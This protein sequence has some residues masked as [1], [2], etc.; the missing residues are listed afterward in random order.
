MNATTRIERRKST[1]YQ[2]FKKTLLAMPN[3]SYILL[4]LF[5]VVCFAIFFTSSLDY[6]GKVALIVFVIAMILW[7]ATKLP[8]G[9]VALGAILSIILLKGADASLLYDSFSLEIVW[10]M[11]GAFIIGEVIKVSGLANRI[12]TN[13]MKNS[14][15]SNSV[16]FHVLIALL[17]LSI[18]IP[19]TSGRAAITLPVVKELAPFIQ[20]DKHKQVLAMFV[21]TII[22]MTTSATLIGAGSHLIGVEILE[23]T[24]GETITYLNWLI[25]GVPFA[26]FISFVSY[27]AVRLLW[28]R[29]KS[30]PLLSLTKKHSIFTKNEK[31][32]EKEKKALIFIGTLFLLWVTE[33]IHGHDIGFITIMGALVFMSPKF[34]L[35]SWKQGVKSVSWNLILFVSAATALGINLVETGVVDWIESSIFQFVTSFSNFSVWGMLCFILLVSITSHLYITSHTTRAIVLVPGLL[36]LGTSFGFNGIAVLFLSLVGMNYCLTFPVSSKALLVY[37]EEEKISYKAKD[38]M[39]LSFLLMPIYFISILLFYYTYW[40]WTGLTL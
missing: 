17:P 39:R 35:L 27:L 36:M 8:A 2:I 18:F 12:I 34:G 7:I 32:T 38:L 14:A 16:L 40:D 19:S 22:L 6:K 3:Y 23:K 13:I 20:D 33:G 10:L 4:S 25:W 15:T 5:I 9:Y 30:T 1:S 37:F 26:I 21:P 24:T 29:G 11:I 28:M 31:I